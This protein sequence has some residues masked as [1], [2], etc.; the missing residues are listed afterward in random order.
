[1]L[2]SFVAVLVLAVAPVAVRAADEENPYKNSKVG[3]FA[4]YTMTTAVAGIT[5][6]GTITQTVT[7]KDDKEATILKRLEVYHTQTKQLVDYYSKMAA[8]GAANAPRYRKVSGLGS[9]DEIRDRIFT[10]LAQ[11]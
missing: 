10:A 1:M 4:T 3:D 8:S 5:I 6:D 2:R 7:K 9:M 11:A